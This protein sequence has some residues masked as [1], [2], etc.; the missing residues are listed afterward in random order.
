MIIQLQ[1]YSNTGKTNTIKIY[2][3]TI[4]VQQ[5][6][7]GAEDGNSL[8]YLLLKKMRNASFLTETSNT[9]YA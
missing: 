9:T 7:I 6:L 5:T 8:P 2:N 4:S 3:D 1:N